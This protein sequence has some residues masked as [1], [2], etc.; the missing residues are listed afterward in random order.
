MLFLSYCLKT[1]FFYLVICPTKIQKYL[2]IS[3][4]T[5]PGGLAM[6]YRITPMDRRMPPVPDGT[7]CST[8]GSVMLLLCNIMSHIRSKHLKVSHQWEI[9]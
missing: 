3:C 7:I 4:L 1:E 8:P 9:F 2:S 6:Y 5:G